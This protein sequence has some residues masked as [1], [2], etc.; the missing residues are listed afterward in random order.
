MLEEFPSAAA[1]SVECGQHAMFSSIV[2]AE[3]VIKATINTQVA[4]SEAAESGAGDPHES[5]VFLEC[6]DAHKVG[7]GFRWRAPVRP[8]QLVQADE[9]IAHEDDGDVLPSE[10]GL[11]VMPTQQPVV[12]EEAF[13]LCR[14]VPGVVC[15]HPEHGQHEPHKSGESREKPAAD[16]R[17]TEFAVQRHSSARSTS[18]RSYLDN[19]RRT[20]SQR[21]ATPLN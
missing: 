15:S 17:R 2:A 1:V 9:V 21:R 20:T 14:I 12:G 4:M 5:K 19:V 16:M 8:F 11:L 7:A 13:F 3:R 18:M 6:I 10:T